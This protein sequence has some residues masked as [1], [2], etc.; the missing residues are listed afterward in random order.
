MAESARILGVN[1]GA[2]IQQDAH[3]RRI[4]RLDGPLK[5]GLPHEKTLCLCLSLQTTAQPPS[6]RHYQILRCKTSA[7]MPNATSLHC[8]SDSNIGK[9]LASERPAIF[10]RHCK[11]LVGNVG[12]QFFQPLKFFRLGLIETKKRKF[13]GF[14]ERCHA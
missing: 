4:R 3:Q 13:E 5:K 14:G 1:V 2:G 10:L 12:V 11:D 8:A 7:F 6:R 9:K